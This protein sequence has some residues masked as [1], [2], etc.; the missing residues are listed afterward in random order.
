MKQT[1]LSLSAAA[2]MVGGLVGVANASPLQPNI[3]GREQLQGR[4]IQDVQ[5]RRCWWEDGRRICRYSYRD[6]DWRDRDRGWWRW[7]RHRDFD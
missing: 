1:F 3:V 6:R 5:W 2:C 4:A 7:R